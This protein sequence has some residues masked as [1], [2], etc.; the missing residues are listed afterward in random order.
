MC[1]VGLFGALDGT[2]ISVRVDMAEK[3]RYRTSKGH[4]AT[5]TLDACTR[6]MRFT[7]V[8]SGWE[9]SAGDAR[10]LRDAVTCDSG[11]KVPRCIT[12]SQLKIILVFT[13]V[14]HIVLPKQGYTFY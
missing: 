5:N 9:E 1:L 7:Y 11:L 12:S 10:V 8:L 3:P 13:C 2:Y 4:I 6:D 14:Y